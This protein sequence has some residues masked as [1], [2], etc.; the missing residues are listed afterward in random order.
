VCGWTNSTIM[1]RKRSHFIHV[2]HQTQKS[3]SPPHYAFM[4]CAS[5]TFY[6][7]C[8]KSDGELY[9]RMAGGRPPSGFMAFHKV[10]LSV[11]LYSFGTSLIV[12][13]REHD[14]AHWIGGWVDPGAGLD[15]VAKR[16]TPSP[17]RETNPSRPARSR[18]TILTE[19][20]RLLYYTFGLP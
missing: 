10:A 4:L 16:K 14:R 19:L 15:A 2:W 3:S 8:V 9:T 1:R 12:W 6:D 11:R 17:Y 13:V 5:G 18:I 7:E 20:P